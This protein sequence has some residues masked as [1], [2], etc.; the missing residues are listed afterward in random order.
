MEGPRRGTP[1]DPSRHARP[2]CRHV[3]PSGSTSSILAERVRAGSN[4]DRGE[5]VSLVGT[6][7]RTNGG[8]RHRRAGAETTRL[9]RRLQRSLLRAGGITPRLSRSSCLL[10]M[11]LRHER[12]GRTLRRR[13]STEPAGR[14]LGSSLRP[15]PHAANILK[16]HWL[17]WSPTGRSRNLRGCEGHWWANLAACQLTFRT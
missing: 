4:R 8:R 2:D 7:R 11:E 9:H 5:T 10:G 3:R 16:G 1:R 13:P 6:T 15:S 14:E 17:S 12:S